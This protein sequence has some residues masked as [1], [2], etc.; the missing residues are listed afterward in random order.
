M[1]SAAKADGRLRTTNVTTPSLP[2][3]LPDDQPRPLAAPRRAGAVD[4]RMPDG[5]V[6]TTFSPSARSWA[7][8]LR[9]SD[10]RVALLGSGGMSHRFWPLPE[11][12]DHM[13]YGPEDVISDEARAADQRVLDWWARATT[14]P[15]STSTPSSGRLSPEGLLRALPDDRGRARRSS[16]AT[17]AAC[18]ARSTRRRR[19]GAG[20]RVVRARSVGRND[21]RGLTMTLEGWTLPADRHR[22]CR[23]PHAAA[24]ALLGRDHLGRLHRRS[25]GRRG[26]AAPRDRA[27]RRRRGV[28]RLR[29]LVLGVAT[30]TPAIR[31]DPARGQ[32]KEAY[33]GRSTGPTTASPSGACPS[34]GS[35][36]ISRSCAA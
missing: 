6:A 30:T 16:V 1:H 14:P 12:P 9:S 2:V 15:S 17:P 5:D 34:S 13:G 32:Y 3:P 7:R 21:T 31:D 8:P 20:A 24:V 26:A 27:G 36:A 28:V 35:T 19:H 25:D 4:R 29:R 10:H 18:S 11:L 33:A 23:D 22:P